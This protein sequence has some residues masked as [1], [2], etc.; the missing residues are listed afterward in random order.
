MSSCAKC[1]KELPI[2]EGAG[3]PR[4][5]CGDVCQRAATMEIRRLDARIAK[6]EKDESTYRIKGADGW[7]KNAAK[8]VERLEARLAQ[9]VAAS[10]DADVC[11]AGG[12]V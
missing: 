9:L 1:G 2:Q 10:D 7:A 6:L 11:T 4:R 12:G 5:Y 8:E 3:R